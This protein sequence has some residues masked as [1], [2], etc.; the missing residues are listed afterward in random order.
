MFCTWQLPENA[1]S[2]R[3]CAPQGNQLLLVQRLMRGGSLQ[4]ALQ[5]AGTREALRWRAG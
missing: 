1:A 5:Q 4:Q 2:S 3:A